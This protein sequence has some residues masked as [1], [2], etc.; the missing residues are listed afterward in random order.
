MGTT[1]HEQEPQVLYRRSQSDPHVLI[2][3]FPA[4]GHINSMLKLAELLCHAGLHVTFL[5]S[6]YNHDRLLRY[7]DVH[8]RFSRWP[9]FRFETITDGLPVDHSRSVDH[10]FDMFDSI[11][12]ITKPLFRDMLISLRRSTEDRPP[13]TCV[14]ADGIMSFTIDVAEELGI[15]IISFRTISACCFWAYFCIPKLVEVGELPF[16][17]DEDMDRPITCVPGMESFLRRRDLPSFCRAKD[18]SN[19]TLQLVI[20]ETQNTSRA[21]ALILN[22]FDDLEGPILSQ[23]RNHCPKLYT[24]GPLHALRKSRLPISSPAV[25]SNSLWEED[26]SCMTWL[27]SQ[28]SK[29]VVYV[30][31]GSIA[32]V[33]RDE[34]LEFWYGL[35]NSEKP[36]LW[37]MRS[38]FVAGKEGMRQIPAELVDGTKERGCLVGWAPQEEV[39]AHTSVG[40]FL[41]HSG[42]NS[43]LESVFSGVPMICWPYFADQQINS[44]FVGEVWKLGLDMK[45]KCDRGTVENMVKELIEGRREELTK[46]ADKMAK[47]ARRS[48][49]EG[50]SSY[51]NFDRLIQDIISMSL[52]YSG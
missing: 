19:S 8:A 31:F 47:L 49:S 44:R 26:R 36:F 50:G 33:T 16:N 34:L 12:L 15:P 41:T 48:V 22:T 40:G 25:S 38:D 13:L 21:S 51:S 23:I 24:I 6:D 27:D 42:W 10:V 39:L 2:F 3:P 9:G 28:P 17:G 52:P 7:T 37:V 14:I 5:N 45:D 20:T 35:V 30:S 4:Q 11:K 1:I 18:L 46:S 29:S 32:V 43:T